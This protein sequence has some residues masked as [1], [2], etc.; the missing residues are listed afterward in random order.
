VDA[1][2][3]QLDYYLQIVFAFILF[4]QRTSLFKK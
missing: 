1:N 3:N 2:H 4:F